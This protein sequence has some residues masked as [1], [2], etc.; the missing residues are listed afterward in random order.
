M[1]SVDAFFFIVLSFVLFVL[2]RI[3][4]KFQLLKSL[5][6]K[7]CHS[8]N[9]DIYQGSH[10][11]WKTLKT[12]K[13]GGCYSIHGNIMELCNSEIYHGKMKHVKRRIPVVIVT[14][15]FFKMW[16]GPC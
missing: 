8:T 16:Q 14:F 2:F 13:S 11:T 5:K 7:V 12:R 10:S 1:Y 6:I 9:T 4:H 3:L 15:W